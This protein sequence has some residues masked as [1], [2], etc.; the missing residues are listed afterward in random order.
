DGTRPTRLP[1][2]P[3][4]AAPAAEL[5]GWRQ[6]QLRTPAAHRSDAPFRDDGRRGGRRR[7]ASTGGTAD[8]STPRPGPRGLPTPTRSSRG[9]SRGS[10]GSSLWPDAN[11]PGP[12]GQPLSGL[13]G[14]ERGRVAG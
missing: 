1:S 4:A 10:S 3:A 14:S 8:A 2:G 9:P 13:F 5:A 7:P 12:S 6:P 11:D